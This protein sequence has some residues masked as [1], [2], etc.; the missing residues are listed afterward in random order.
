[1]KITFLASNM[2]LSSSKVST[3]STSLR[4]ER[5]LASNFLAAQGPINATLQPGCFFLIN[6]PVSTI[7]VSAIE[8]ESAC[9][10]KSFLAMTDHA[11]Q[12]DVAMKGILSGT[13][14]MKSF[15]SMIVQRSAPIATSTQSSNPRALNADLSLLGGRSGPNCP[16]TAG[17]IAAYTGTFTFLIACI[18]W[19]I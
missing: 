19:N 18:S 14:S 2:P 12:Q 8:T 17:A 5:R 1:M 11:G 10:G 15:A 16:V 3:K 13:S 9:C 7:G 6:L 4:I